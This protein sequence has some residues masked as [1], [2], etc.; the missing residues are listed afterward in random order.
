MQTH[1]P[2]EKDH[3]GKKHKIEDEVLVHD[4]FISDLRFQISNFL[5]LQSAI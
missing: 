1:A 3:R 4:Q 5:N 2:K